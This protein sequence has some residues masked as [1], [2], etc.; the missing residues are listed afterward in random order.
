MSKQA[1]FVSSL[2]DECFPFFN[3]KKEIY[4]N[5]QKEKLFY[6]FLIDELRVLI[7]VQGQ[8]HYEFIE[9]FHK[10]Y[11]NFQKQ[12]KR[13]KLKEEWAEDNG[14]TLLKIEYS[15]ELDK[16]IF[17]DKIREALDAE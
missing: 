6:D 7:E 4:V 13:D 15:D 9:F 17:L 5:Y 2:I 3:K 12:K 8:Q 10:S 16:G 1:D 14:Y 11:F